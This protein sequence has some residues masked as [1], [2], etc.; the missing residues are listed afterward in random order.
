MPKQK[1][2]K[3]EILEQ[4][5]NKFLWKGKDLINWDVEVERRMMKELAGKCFGDVLVMGYEMGLIQRYLV[6]NLK[7]K[8][9]ITIEKEQELVE[10]CQKVYE[11]VYGEVFIGNFFKDDLG[12]KFDCIVSD[13]CKKVVLESLSN[14]KRFK[15]RAEKLLKPHGIILGYGKNY[16]EYLIDD[17]SKKPKFKVENSEEIIK[18]GEIS[19]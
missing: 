10:E 4:K 12:M 18:V 17:K 2:K 3:F 19:I 1:K 9:V 13:V 14:Y 5:G 7:V 15:K 16:F 11:D 8:K 6:K